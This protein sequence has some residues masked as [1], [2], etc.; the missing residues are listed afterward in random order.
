MNN[1]GDGIKWFGKLSFINLYFLNIYKTEL[2]CKDF[3]VIRDAC[4]LH[5]ISLNLTDR[6][7]ICL[8]LLVFNSKWHLMH[9]IFLF[10]GEKF[11]H[12]NIFYI[13]FRA[14]SYLFSFFTRFTILLKMRDNN[15]SI[16]IL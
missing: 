13:V 6:L 10:I 14:T 2:F 16:Q 7:V 15:L 3:F 8:K 5:T 11:E 4:F 12:F 1:A 9:F